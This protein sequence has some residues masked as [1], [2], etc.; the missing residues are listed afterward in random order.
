MYAIVDIETTGG[1]AA[2]NSITEIA[3][4]LFD[5]EKVTGSYQTLINPGQRIPVYVQ[6][7]TG[8][9]D[10]M[11]ANAPR[12]SEVAPKIFELLQDRVFV[13]HSV[14]FDFSFVKYQ[15]Q[16]EGFELKSKKLCTV[17]LSRKLLPGYPSYS[18]GNLCDHLGIHI[19]GRHRA[20]GDAGA[21]VA[22]FQ[23][24]LQNDTKGEILKSLKRGSK[25]QL[26][27][28]H[29]PKEHFEQLPGSPGVYYFHDQKGKVIY[30][31]KAVNIRSR[32]TSHFSNNATSK[33]KQN[34]VRHIHAISFERC[35]TELMAHVLES[36]EIK[37]L[38]PEFNRAQKRWEDVYG[39]YDYCD[40]NGYIRLAIEKL[41]KNI[42]PIYTFHYL[43][44]GHNLIKQLL[45][46][47]QLC[48]KLCYIQ[49]G[50]DTCMGIQEAYC[51][52]ACEQKEAPDTYNRRVE[53]AIASLSHQPSF[54]IVDHGLEAD[55]QS[56]ILVMEGR[57]YGIGYIPADI[58]IDNMDALKD[59]VT[60]V[61]EN[62]YI[63]QLVYKYA[64][65]H[66]RKVL[67]TLS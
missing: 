3:I 39:I 54:A 7:L 25:E 31:G 17:R 36:H 27:P 10:D 2:S 40:Q 30:V 21:T 44:E 67:H 23:L 50:N 62:A 42:R 28:P 46:S 9:T 66:P 15:L 63:R 5:G 38:W 33:Q 19:Q 32:V 47:F 16:K 41:K 35:A 58:P 13:A 12:F 22:L 29:V 48:P 8:I 4:F 14:N 18:L 49:K 11:V 1:H 51:L 59:M 45:S 55:T 64:S 57:L 20:A 24:I 53:A 6:G 60:P 52:G 26:L 43:L 34:F 37:R 61:K 56:C 65:E